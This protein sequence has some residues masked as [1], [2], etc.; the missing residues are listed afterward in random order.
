MAWKMTPTDVAAIEKTVSKYLRPFTGDPRMKMLVSE[1]RQVGVA[2]PRKPSKQRKTE[3]KPRNWTHEAC[4]RVAKATGERMKAM[5]AAA[6][7]T[8]V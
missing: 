6:K 1:L 4:A 3:T 7:Q 5:W 2:I 8:G